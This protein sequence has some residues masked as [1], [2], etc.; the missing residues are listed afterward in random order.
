MRIGFGYDIH[1]FAPERKLV[2]GGVEIP[3]ELG[4]KGHSDAD[5]LIHA[6]CDALLGAAALGDIGRHFP[7]NDPQYEDA[8]SLTF[9]VTVKSLLQAEKYEIANVDATLVLERPR[10]FPF[11]SAMRQAIAEAL[12]IEI[13][14]ISIKATTNEGLGAL[15]R[16]EG[17]AAYAVAAL[18]LLTSDRSR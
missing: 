6:I 9:L 11:I 3:F 1:C 5:V 17:C 7:D 8:S 15:G 4:L 13:A 12:G 2:L 14:R 16:L 10:I 18:Q